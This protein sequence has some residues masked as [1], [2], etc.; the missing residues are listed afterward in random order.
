APSG[1]ITEYRIPDGERPWG[2]VTGADGALWYTAA[3][4]PAVGRLTIDG[5]FSPSPFTTRTGSGDAAPPLG[6]DPRGIARGPTGAIWF[7]EAGPNEV[8]CLGFANHR[9]LTAAMP[10]TPAS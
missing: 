3:T 6:L 5:H 10:N 4:G 9:C 7:V 1:L 2:I 8:I